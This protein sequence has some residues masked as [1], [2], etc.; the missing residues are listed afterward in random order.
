MVGILFW[1]SEHACYT[2][3]L[4]KR[5][6]I[7]ILVLSRPLPRF[8][9]SSSYPSQTLNGGIPWLFKT[10]ALFVLHA[11]K[12]TETVYHHFI[13]CSPLTD[14]YNSLWSNLKTK[15]I[16]FNQ[17]DGITMSDFIT[18]LDPHKKVLLLV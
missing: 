9:Q 13:E 14:N 18:N 2:S 4:R 16:N 15:I 6:C 8:G 17:T 11:K 5:L 1:L 3:L 12:N 10:E 7:Q